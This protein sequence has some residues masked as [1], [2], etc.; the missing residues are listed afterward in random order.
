METANLLVFF[1]LRVAVSIFGIILLILLKRKKIT[2]TT[3]HILFLVLVY[4]FFAYGASI[5]TNINQIFAWNLSIIVAGIFWPYF[6]I[7]I[8][9]RKTILLNICFSTFYLIF[10]FFNSVLSLTDLL[11]NGGVFFIFA[12]IASPIIS[13]AKY[14][15]HLKD[16]KHKLEFKILN[17]NLEKLNL[18][19]KET[20]S[21]KNRFFSIIAH[22]LKGPF[23]SLLGFSNILIENIQNKNYDNIEKYSQIINNGLEQTYN[24][25][26]NL[27]QWSITQTETNSFLP[28]NLILSELVSEVAGNLKHLAEQKQI[29]FSSFINSELE[30]YADKDMLETVLRNL[31]SNAIKYTN[32]G[33]FVTISAETGTNETIIT[34]KDNGVGIKPSV[35]ENL[36]KIE[37]SIST[38][39]TNNEKGTG[40][41]LSL[42][43]ALI[44]TH[45]GKI[46]ASSEFG[47][48]SVFY[49]SI[50]IVNLKNQ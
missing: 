21:V 14:R 13:F 16:F 38:Q 27:L 31:I 1:I 4:S 30:I 46:W 44:E 9:Y 7:I 19:L 34:V 26:N 12:V 43:K 10:Y 11:I 35:L 50:P 37:K 40:L 18:E 17:Q 3:V 36:F 42:C 23:N 45:K 15:M 29:A 20:I 33:G 39:G 22:D 47:K 6:I 41:G 49:L 32:N 24:L 8:D 25:T 48:G 5:L 2:S 28:K